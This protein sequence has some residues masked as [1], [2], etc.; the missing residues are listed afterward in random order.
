MPLTHGGH[1]GF[2]VENALAAAAAA[3]VLGVPC[4]VILAG[5]ESFVADLERAPA[6]FNL[7]EFNGATVVLDYGHNISSLGL[8]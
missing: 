2:Q 5:L 8:A 7:L 6:R 4:E 1:V 3:W